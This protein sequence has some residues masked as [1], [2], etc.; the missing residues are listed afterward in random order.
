MCHICQMAR[1]D[2]MSDDVDFS[3]E[4]DRVKEMVGD[5]NVTVTELGSWGYDKRIIKLKYD[6]P[7]AHLRFMTEVLLNPMR[8]LGWIVWNIDTSGVIFRHESYHDPDKYIDL[9]ID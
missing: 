2:D 6:E 4:V 1:E 8:R 3:E 5:Q 9:M 7:D